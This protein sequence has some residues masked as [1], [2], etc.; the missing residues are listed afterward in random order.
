MPEI[1]TLDCKKCNWFVIGCQCQKFLGKD[2]E[3]TP[4]VSPFSHNL[5]YYVSI[6]GKAAN[7]KGWKITWET[8]PE[9]LLSTIAELVDAHERGWRDDKKEKVEVEIGDCF[10]RLFHICHD[11]NIDIESVLETIIKNNEK[12]KHLHGH[13]RM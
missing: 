1:K 5:K 13:V 8:L 4:R 10:I 6:C 2:C 12:R 9:Y 7:N 11:L 3:F